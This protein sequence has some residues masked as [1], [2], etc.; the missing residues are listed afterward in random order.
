MTMI[1]SAAAASLAGGAMLLCAMS[2]QAVE[3][4]FS[5]AEGALRGY[6]A[7]AYFSEH[8]AVKGLPQF[9]WRWQ[10]S[11]WRFASATN[12]TAFQADPEKYAPQFGGYCAY[13]VS[14]GYAPETDPT[15][16]SIIDGKLYLNYNHAVSAKWRQDT[17]GYIAQGKKNWPGLKDGSFK[18]D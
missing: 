6:D 10:G 16:Y 14:Q 8:K 17:A 5:T 7:V 12:M 9:S 18:P 11:E 2:A 1:K 3:P 4:Y 15:A 13:G